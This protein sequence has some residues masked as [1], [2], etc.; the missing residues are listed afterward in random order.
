MVCLNLRLKDETLRMSYSTSVLPQTSSRHVDNCSQCADWNHW[1]NLHIEKAEYFHKN[2]QATVA[3][4]VCSAQRKSCEAQAHSMAPW[5]R[6]RFLKEQKY[7]QW[8]HWQGSHSAWLSFKFLCIRNCLWAVVLTLPYLVAETS[9]SCP[10][11]HSVIWV[12]PWWMTLT[13]LRIHSY[14]VAYDLSVSQKILILGERAGP[15]SALIP[16]EKWCSFSKTK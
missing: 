16:K 10:I 14:T 6:A 1:E 11:N 9:L 15:N 2:Q 13:C 3:E 7:D 8:G 5:V 12:Q 4:E